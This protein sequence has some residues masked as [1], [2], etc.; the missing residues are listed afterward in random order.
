MFGFKWFSHIEL[1]RQ[2][3]Y[4]RLESQHK[5]S[6]DCTFT[7]IHLVYYPISVASAMTF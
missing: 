4:V 7:M 5:F 2:R 1:V 6:A 3:I